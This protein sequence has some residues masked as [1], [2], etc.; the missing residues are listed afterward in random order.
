RFISKKLLRTFVMDSPPDA[1]IDRIADVYKDTNGDIRQ[2]LWAIFQS[3]EFR[4]PANFGGKVKT[5]MEMVISSIRA[6]NG[7]IRPKT[8][9]GT[10]TAPCWDGYEW[11]QAW[12][13]IYN[14]GQR[15]FEYPIPTGYPEIAEPWISANGFLQRW[16]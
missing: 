14:Q 9:C 5:P 7:S 6:T 3:P 1:L 15:L 2:V 13:W 8:D 11:P 16:K 10:A 12:Y 4:D